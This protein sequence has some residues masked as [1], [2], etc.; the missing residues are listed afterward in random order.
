MPVITLDIIEKGKTKNGAWTKRQLEILGVQ[1]PPIKGWKEDVKK[2]LL[3][4][5]KEQINEFIEIGKSTYK[6]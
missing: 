3:I 6:K 2:A 1:W 4:L 5:D